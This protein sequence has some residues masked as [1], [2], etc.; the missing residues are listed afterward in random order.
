MQLTRGL[1]RGENFWLHLTTASA[2]CLCLSERFLHF[3]AV[4][5][6]YLLERSEL[7]TYEVGLFRYTFFVGYPPKCHH[8]WQNYY[9]Y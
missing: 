5:I 6:D 2:Q 1:W 4:G 9:Y 3:N 7:P 8:C